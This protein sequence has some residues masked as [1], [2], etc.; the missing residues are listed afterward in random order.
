MG[1]TPAHQLPYPEDTEPLQQ[2]AYHIEQLATRLDAIMAED[3][4]VDVAQ[5][6]VDAGLGTAPALVGFT[7]AALRMDG[8]T[9]DGATLTYTG[10]SERSFMVAVEVATVVEGAGIASATVQLRH[11]GAAF[12]GSHDSVSAPGVTVRRDYTHRI[13]TPIRLAPGQTLDVV[14]NGNVAG[15]IDVT[16]LRVYPIGPHA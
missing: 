15:T 7:G 2:V 6:G 8:F 10:A 16:S 1:T 3:T 13:T 9:F 4:Q 5:S 12:T 11:N 14:A